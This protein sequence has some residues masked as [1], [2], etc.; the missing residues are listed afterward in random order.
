MAALLGVGEV[1]LEQAQLAGARRRRR[2]RHRRRDRPARE[3]AVRPLRTCSRA[4]SLRTAGRAS[5]RRPREPLY[6]ID[7][8]GATRGR[9]ARRHSE[10]RAGAGRP[11]DERRRGVDRHAGRSR[12]GAPDPDDVLRR[13]IASTRFPTCRRA[14]R[15]GPSGC[16][17]TAAARTQLRFYLTFLVGPARRARARRVGVRLQLERDGQM[18]IYS[19]SAEVDE[20]RCSRR[21]RPRRSARN[22]V[23]LDGSS[24]ASRSIC[25]PSGGRGA[26]DGDARRSTPTPGRSLPPSTSAA[27]AAGSPATP[28][29]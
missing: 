22:S 14:R 17:S 16:T 25:P 12:V 6:L 13:W 5:P 27:P 4:G 19:A 21:A 26:A 7:G 24:T 23:R 1:I 29:R 9:G 11:G 15:R 18:T 3:R 8:D 2:R 20:R 28:C 10:P